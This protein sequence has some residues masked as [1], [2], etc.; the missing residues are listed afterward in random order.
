MRIADSDG[1]NPFT[2]L[3][4]L[5]APLPCVVA[6]WT[7]L[8]YVSFE[9]RE[10]RIFIQNLYTEERS[11]VS[12]FP[13]LNGA[14][15][16]SPD[17]EQL[18]LTLS[19]DGIR[20]STFSTLQQPPAPGTLNSAID[21]EAAWSPDGNTLAFTSDRGG[22]AQVYTVE[23]AGGKPV[24]LTFE[25][26]YNARPRYRRTG[27]SSPSCTSRATSS[28]LRCSTSRAANFASSP[29]PNSTSRPALRPMGMI[30]YSTIYTTSAPWRRFPPT[31][32]APATRC[33]ARCGARAGMV[34]LSAS[35]SPLDFEYQFSIH[36]G[37]T[38]IDAY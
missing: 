26:R 22:R 17:G 29:R 33:S 24:R 30:L 35:V 34:A 19:K 28:E 8:A 23:A 12:S 25:G 6:G 1:H 20:R 13:G 14:P 15:A 36:L 7:A 16:W 10:P 18:A 3:V 2:I 38:C 37:V 11:M 27:A 5:T 31:P 21:T 4:L 32:H 9:K